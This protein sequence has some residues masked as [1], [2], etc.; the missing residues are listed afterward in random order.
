MARPHNASTLRNRN[1]VTTKTRLRIAFGDVQVDEHIPDEGDKDAHNYGLD[2]DDSKELHISQILSARQISQKGT[3]E[4]PQS[5]IPTPESAVVEGYEKRHPQRKWRDPATYVTHSETVDEAWVCGLA[6]GCTYFMDERDKAWLDKNNEDARGEGTSAAA[7]VSPHRLSPRSAKTKGKEPEASPAVVMDENAFELAMGLFEL[8]THREAEFLHHGFQGA[9]SIPPFSTYQTLFGNPLR[10]EYFSRCVV[11]T[12][13]PTPALLLQIGRAIYPHWRQRRA[14]RN[15]V[16]IISQLNFDEADT[17]NESYVCFRRREMKATRKTRGQQANMAERLQSLQRA[18][19]EPLRLAQLVMRRENL[20]RANND[21]TCASWTRRLAMLE[22]IRRDP[23]LAEKGDEELLVDREAAV[24]RKPEARKEYTPKIDAPAPTPPQLP[25]LMRPSDRTRRINVNIETACARRKEKDRQWD[26]ALETPFIPPFAAPTSSLFKI[27]SPSSPSSSV[28]SQDDEPEWR[29]HRNA[30]PAVR[31]RCARGGRY[32]MDRR[33]ACPPLKRRRLGLDG[34][35]DSDTLERIAERYRFDQEDAPAV[36]TGGWEEQERQ[37]ENDYT[38]RAMI[39]TLRIHGDWETR[40]L[41]DTSVPKALP[42]GSVEM[43]QPFPIVTTPPVRRAPNNNGMMIS[44]AA[45]QAQASA[46]AGSQVPVANGAPISMQM[47][48]SERPMRISSNGGMRTPVSGLQ[49][50]PSSVSPPH[51]AAQFATPT[52]NGAANGTRAALTMPHVDANAM[53]IQQT[54]PSQ[55]QTDTIM[56]V[57]YISR[58]NSQDALSQS[59]TQL[60][61]QQLQTVKHIMKMQSVRHP[62]QWS[63]PSRPGT[64]FDGAVNVPASP[65]NGHTP[66]RMMMSPHMQHQNPPMPQASPA[67]IM[68]PGQGY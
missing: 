13:L 31:I 65:P 20:K 61:M 33:D 43:V 66:R 32:F 50:P 57:G 44:Q 39:G 7:G 64:G 56:N 3:K 27:M 15:G 62:P 47:K 28:P 12:K 21:I 6:D 52:V 9:D 55:G 60:S 34:N 48:M 23:T 22:F 68:A 42:D 53:N 19:E 67:P 11:P 51:S 54:S 10:P 59:S 18:L 38:T 8:A 37:L 1:R 41:K 35:D 30:Q 26:D 36:G 45:Q 2:A 40:L 16:R 5:Y 14:E 63:P 58:S 49:S 17:Q 25:P 4:A 29:L 24:V 46:A